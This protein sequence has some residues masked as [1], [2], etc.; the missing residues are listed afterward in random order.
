M[1][2]FTAVNW[3]TPDND[4][5]LMFW[6]QNI[7]QFWID[8]E[9]I[10]SKDIDSWKGLSWDMKECYKKALG[11]LTLLDTLQSH[12]GMPKIIDHIDS[13]QNKAVL[14]YMCMMEAIH[15]KSYSTIFTTVSTTNEINDVFGWVE[16]NKFLQFKGLRS[17]NITGV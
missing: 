8:T 7:K 6:E 1:K 12:T 5:A 3:N 4:Y 14:S 10:P 13:L 9:Y 15:A 17:I 2:Q 16:Q 11:G